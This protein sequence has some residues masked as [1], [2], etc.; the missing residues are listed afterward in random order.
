MQFDWGNAHGDFEMEILNKLI[1]Y[2]SMSDKKNRPSPEF[3]DVGL[4]WNNGMDVEIMD[5]SRFSAAETEIGR[6]F[7]LDGQRIFS[8]SNASARAEEKFNQIRHSLKPGQWTL[9]DSSGRVQQFETFG[10]IQPYIDSQDQD[11]ESY[12]YDYVG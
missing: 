8:T 6:V 1:R 12:F 7:Y 11:N 2:V 10:E 5:S 9:V 3:C 4:C